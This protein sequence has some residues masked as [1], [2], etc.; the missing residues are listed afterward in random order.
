M[1]HRLT[2]NKLALA[3]VISIILAVILSALFSL[4]VFSLFNKQL[5]DKLYSEKL[6]ISDI[7]IIAI[8]DKSLQEIGRWPWDRSVHAQMLD[9]IKNS[10]RVVAFDISFFEPSADDSKFER[11]INQTENVTL[12]VEY[13]QFSLRD[14][15][16]YGEEILGPV[17]N[18]NYY[19]GFANIFTDM[20]G[21][22]RSFP[23]YIEGVE[24][25]NSLDVAVVKAYLGQD[26]N[27]GDK[28]IL[29]N[30]IGPP[31]S[32]P[33]YSYSDII[34]GEVDPAVFAGKIV[35][36]GATAPD[37]R[38]THLTP[39][40]NIEMPGVEVH[41]NAIQTIL[42]GNFIRYQDSGSVITLIFILAIITGLILYRFR[43][44]IATGLVL[45]LAIIYV[46]AAIF[47]FDSGLILN[48]VYP[49]LTF[50]IVYVANVGIFYMTE[51][52]QRKLVTNVFGKYVSKEVADE[53]LKKTTSE[54]LSLKGEK[55][56][57][58]IMFSDI[59][60]FTSISEKLSPEEL[61]D[62]LNKYLSAMTDIVMQH[63]GVVDKYIGDAI[64]A[65]WGAP[66][67][68]ENHATLACQAAVNMIKK[69][70]ELNI[71][72]LAIGIGI[73]TG[74]A[75]V[76]NM[77]SAQRV[78]Y[79]VIGDAVN[80]ASRLEGLNKEYHTSIIIGESTYQKVKDEFMC[81]E[82]DFIKVK[83]KEHPIRIYEL[84]GKK[85]EVDDKILKLIEHF[86]SGL[87]YYRKK[88]WMYAIAEFRLALKV[89]HDY[90]S[91]IFIER[92]HLLQKRTPRDW[93]GVF[94]WK[95]K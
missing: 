65:F 80:A 24:N 84:I 5:S 36:I 82:L 55:R 66:L 34:N 92:C 58:T 75:V 7:V 27:L 95:T 31:D 88:K 69:L 12:V 73:N 91:H 46:I 50:I 9:K 26:V 18:A 1:L 2:K 44:I 56:E 32:F 57:I 21:V 60:G 38:D 83:G 42:T 68:E 77:G 72:D 85:G 4:G 43:L 41:A 74:E 39:F 28:P 3:L 53:I 19:V 22:V 6:P 94:T 81:R 11:A 17:F 25:Y 10:A 29:I 33:Y 67:K 70:K 48:I 35:L 15:R 23:P 86:H 14:D 52:R 71:P 37:L 59:R 16:L 78:N 76:G 13:T 40:S 61:V 90:P 89:Q 20:D 8:D 45:V 64:M 54:K 51:S 62:F 47:I 87:D 30:Y 49:I 93:D 63:R 79:T